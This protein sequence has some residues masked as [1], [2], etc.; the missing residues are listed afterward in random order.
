V[1]PRSRRASNS[2][3]PLGGDFEAGR[4]FDR[5]GSA[6]LIER[7]AVGLRDQTQHEAGTLALRSSDQGLMREYGPRLDIDDGLEGHGDGRIEADAVAAVSA[8]HPDN[9]YSA[10]Q[11]SS[12]CRAGG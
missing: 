10:R 4:K 5:G 2:I 9:S 11:A 12:D 1:T 3:G 8:A 7:I 6:K